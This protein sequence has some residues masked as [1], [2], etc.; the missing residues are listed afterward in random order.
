MVL[1]KKIFFATIALLAILAVVNHRWV[2]YVA[3]LAKHQGGVIF[4]KEK[5]TE[6]LKK[7]TLTNHER[8]SLEKTLKIRAYIEKS[9]G[10]NNSH[11]YR[12]YYD[13]GRS[14][15]GYNITVAPRFSLK[16][17]A[18]HFWPIGS[19]EYLGFFDRTLAESWANN[20]RAQSFDVHLA[21]IGGYSTLG[22]FEDPLYSTQLAWGDAGL[23]RLLGHEIAH[24][25]LYFKDDTTFSE[26][27]ASFIER[28]IARDYLATVGV[29]LATPVEH[30]HYQN[31]LQSFTA[32]I[33]L[34]K[35][36]LTAVYSS[37]I[38]ATEKLATKIQKI[39]QFREWL[40]T[41]KE[42]RQK[43]PAAKQLSE[44]TEINNATLVQFHRYSA[45]SKAF[46]TTFAACEKMAQP[47]ICWFAALDRLKT[48]S[49][50]ERKKWLSQ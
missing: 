3:H 16:A 17:E 45:T 1:K 24:E 50:A 18:F 8:E 7:S 46:D 31:L 38:S 35:A 30:Q 4:G 12:Y 42:L 2:R 48:Y 23:A 33:E 34:L 15:L 5:I 10:L 28:K 47:Y 40:S 49:R 11:S 13:L 27:L 20:Y 43:I 26:R 39:A 6:R 37:R 19:F 21:E 32:R 9:Y 14:Y 25:R 36:D 29:K 44:L 41:Q 22:W